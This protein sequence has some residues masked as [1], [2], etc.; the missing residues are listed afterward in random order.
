MNICNQDCLNCAYDDCICD[1]MTLADY[2]M[3]LALDRA[4]ATDR[5]TN[6]E[7]EIAAKQKAYREANRDEIAAKRKAYYEAKKRRRAT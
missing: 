1:G 3:S 7:R 5:K 4:A 6:R 2:A